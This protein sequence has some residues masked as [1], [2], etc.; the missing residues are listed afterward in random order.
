MNL[1]PVAVR[2]MISP[3]DLPSVAPEGSLLYERMR[4]VRLTARLLRGEMFPKHLMKD[5]GK[6]KINTSMSYFG[7]LT[8]ENNGVLQSFGRRILSD[9]DSDVRGIFADRKLSNV[10]PGI[11]NVRT[12]GGGGGMRHEFIEALSLT[13]SA[14]FI[15]R[16]ALPRL[17][18]I[19][20]KW[21]NFDAVGDQAPFY[22]SD[23]F[24]ID[25]KV[26]SGTMTATMKMYNDKYC[27]LLDMFLD[28][29]LRPCW[30]YG[31]DL[32]MYV[33]NM[34]LETSLNDG[35]KATNHTFQWKNTVST[36]EPT[37]FVIFGWILNSTDMHLLDVPLECSIPRLESGTLLH[38]GSMVP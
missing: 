33:E 35:G 4:S 21:K 16:T 6:P 38:N 15:S 2:M 10:N 7:V 34:S 19:T 30:N 1:G 26:M 24:K 14:S 36:S 37:R 27:F 31:G 13:A 8:V 32:L 17:L 9:F 20:R 23:D 22:L 11:I 5:D 28:P 3:E 12:P 18:T 25:G 29:V